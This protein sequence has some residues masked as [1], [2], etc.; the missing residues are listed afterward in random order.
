METVPNVAKVPAPSVEVLDFNAT[1]TV[2]AVRPSCHNDHYWD[3]YFA[4][5]EAI[6]AACDEYGYPIPEQRQATRQL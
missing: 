4:T 5:N 2:L 6:A 3:V 1:G